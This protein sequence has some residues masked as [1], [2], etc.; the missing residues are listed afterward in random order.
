M[1]SPNVLP[2]EFTDTDRFLFE[3][4]GYI[5]IPD[6][7]SR[8]EIDELQDASERLHAALDARDAPPR[9]RGVIYEFDPAFERLMDHPKVLPKVHALYGDRFILQAAANTR[10]QPGTP[11]GG[12]HQDG[13]NAYDYKQLG[14]PI[15][16]LQLRVSYLIT[17]QTEPGQGNL[18]LIPGS[19]RAQVGLP[20][21]VREV[22]GDVP[23]GHVLCAEAGTVLIFHN[24]VWH[25][26]Y[27]HN[28][29]NVRYTPHY[30][31]S[32]PW[33]RYSD[34]MQ[35]SRQFLDRTTPLRRA[36]LGDFSR[37]DA[38]FGANYDPL[39]IG[40]GLGSNG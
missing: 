21:H 10:V 11:A 40:A 5:V 6:L 1:L 38:P 27:D 32:P 30:I 23:I 14:H 22:R 36:L 18:E 35:N 24:A 29:P 17:D 28:G 15:P 9:G 20:D 16:L 7:L 25:R 31:Y 3:S 39:P 19:H 33:L 2:G 13:S 26:A 8:S 37:P 12:W 34:R 4:W